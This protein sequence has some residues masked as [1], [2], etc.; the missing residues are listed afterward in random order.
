MKKE[1]TLKER[2][3]SPKPKFWAKVQKV[4]IA[5]GVIGGAIAAAP[6]SLPAGVAV[7]GTYLVTVGAVGA[8]LSQLTV[9]K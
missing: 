9:N 7:A 8:G 4:C 2:V 1:P 5:L 3:F 6:V